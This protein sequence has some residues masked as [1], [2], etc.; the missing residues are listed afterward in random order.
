MNL[1]PRKRD[2]DQSG[3]GDILRRTAAFLAGWHPEIQAAYVFGS[4]A[5]AEA[6]GDLDVAL[7]MATPPAAPLE[8]ELKLEGE[9]EKRVRVPVDVRILNHA[10]PSFQYTVFREGMLILDGDPNKRAA[11]EG[12]VIKQYLDFARFRRRCL[13]EIVRAEI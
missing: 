4:F 10:P 2:L 11:F 7:L 1:H 13:K 12:N 8:F 9:L 3:R 6:F 5:R